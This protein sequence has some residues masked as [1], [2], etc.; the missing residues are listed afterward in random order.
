MAYKE[1]SV[2]QWFYPNAVIIRSVSVFI[3]LHCA[4]CTCALWTSGLV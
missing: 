4:V 3:N 1:V 2:I